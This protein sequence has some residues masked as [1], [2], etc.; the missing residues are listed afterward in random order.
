MRSIA[1]VTTR[2]AE[3]RTAAIPATSSQRRMIMPPWTLPAY[4]GVRDAHPAA[5]LR[6]RLGGWARLHGG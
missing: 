4:V 3:W 2:A 6:A 5:E 1:A